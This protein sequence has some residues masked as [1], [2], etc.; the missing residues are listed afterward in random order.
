[1]EER[2]AHRRTRPVSW[3]CH[4]SRIQSHLNQDTPSDFPVTPANKLPVFFNLLDLGFLSHTA[5]VVLSDT[6][7]CW[8]P[9]WAP[10]VIAPASLGSACCT[11]VLVSL[12]LRHSPVVVA[13][14]IPISQVMK[15]AQRGAVIC[16][17]AHSQS[18]KS[19]I[20][21]VT[22]RVTAASLLLRVLCT[23]LAAPNRGARK[24]P[25]WR[26]GG[27]RSGEEIGQAGHRQVELSHIIWRK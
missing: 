3:G 22:S 11:S 8:H 18:G 19:G 25:S 21:S 13:V 20:S 7:S 17:K 24:T 26:S 16:P 23:A 9:L 6:Q 15:Q 1:M 12:S 5:K 10:E 27:G 2:T 4:N 14:G